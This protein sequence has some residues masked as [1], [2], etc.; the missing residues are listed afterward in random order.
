[1]KQLKGILISVCALM[2]DEYGIDGAKVL[3]IADIRQLIH[4]EEFKIDVMKR[5]AKFGNVKKSNNNYLIDELIK[6]GG[7]IE[8][9]DDNPLRTEA[10]KNSLN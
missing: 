1:M 10:D 7:V 4:S 9:I 3:T 5:M 6:L 8:A 2:A